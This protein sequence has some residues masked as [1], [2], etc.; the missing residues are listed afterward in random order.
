MN[1]VYKYCRGI[2]NKVDSDPLSHIVKNNHK[3]QEPLP[4]PCCNKNL[5]LEKKKTYS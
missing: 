3:M 1:G 5:A 2:F 4:L